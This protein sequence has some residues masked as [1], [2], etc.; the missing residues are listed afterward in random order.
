MQKRT[1][2][3]CLPFFIAYTLLIAFSR[4]QPFFWDTV[5]Q[6]SK[7]AHWYFE[8][9]FSHLF[10][11]AE[12][13]AGHPPGLAMLLAVAWKLFGKT[14][15][16][17]H[18]LMWPFVIGVVW[19]A[20]RLTE[21]FIA[22]RWRFWVLTLLLTD[23]TLLA[24]CS[25]V[26]ADVLMCL[27]T[28]MAVNG[29]LRQK[30]WLLVLA[31]CCMA[32][33][34]LRAIFSISAIALFFIMYNKLKGNRLVENMWSLLPALFVLACW[35]IAHYQ[36]SGWWLSSPNPGWS[37]HREWAGLAAIGKNTAVLAWRMID[38]GR[39][40]EW[41]ALLWL[42]FH[43]LHHRRMP[44]SGSRTLLVF[45]ACFFL[46]YAPLLV[47]GNNPIGHRYLLPAFLVVSLLV[48][49]LLAEYNWSQVKKQAIFILLIAVHLSGHCWIYPD[50]IAQGWDASLAHRPYFELRKQAISY[51]RQQNIP[52]SQVGTAFPN[53]GP[54]KYI[55]LNDAESGFALKKL[56]VQDWF[57]FSNVFNDVFENEQQQLVKQWIEAKSWHSGAI[58]IVLYQ[59]P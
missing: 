14:L 22:P 19:Q 3:L 46:V 1:F 36:A 18:W 39:L 48:A 2:L 31:T 33:C 59:K 12:L 52:L 15:A 44:D 51:L 57:L 55:D 47:L 6:A 7:W 38:F 21:F 50:H 16:V 5:M 43:L 41:L 4:H 42:G 13:D 20:A 30:Y 9:D 45:L 49:R 37:A 54:L 34:S 58:Q 53:I 17:S 40:G 56:D 35:Y 23:A 25:M 26:S 28:L 10:L 32:M 29:I 27:F 24:Q 8:N 11:P